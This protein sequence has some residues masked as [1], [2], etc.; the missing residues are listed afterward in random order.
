MQISVVA[1]GFIIVF[2][3]SVSNQ[4][5]QTKVFMSWLTNP[6]TVERFSKF[7]TLPTRS[8]RACSGFRPILSLDSHDLGRGHVP[9][10]PFDLACRAMQR[11]NPNQTIPVP[12]CD[13]VKS[14]GLSNQGTGAALSH[15]NR[16][17]PSLRASHVRPILPC[18]RALDEAN[19]WLIDEDRLFFLS[20]EAA[21]APSGRQPH[22]ML[23]IPTL[24][25]IS[26][27]EWRPP[28]MG[29]LGKLPCT[30]Q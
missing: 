17:H 5:N 21:A 29:R 13:A 9:P 15:A 6:K 18:L 10:R 14:G 3:L 8:S 22:S 19:A 30:K 26:G 20:F 28:K 12:A 16:Y 23:P 11:Q 1:C 2:D 24:R 25:P 7:E 4:I 27:R